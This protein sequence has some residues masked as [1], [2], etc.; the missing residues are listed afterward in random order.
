MHVWKLKYQTIVPLL[1]RSNIK[2]VKAY[3]NTNDPCILCLQDKLEILSYTNTTEFINKRSEFINK[4]SEII[5][6]SRYL[7]ICLIKNTLLEKAKY[8]SEDK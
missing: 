1:K 5:F 3:L 4:R 2:N 7:K 6:K 8:K